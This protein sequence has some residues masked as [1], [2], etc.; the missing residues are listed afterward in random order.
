MFYYYP[1]KFNPWTKMDYAAL[2]HL[3][4]TLDNGNHDGHQIVIGVEPLENDNGIKGHNL[5]SN[6]E[7][8]IELIEEGLKPLFAHH[9]W[10]LNSKYEY[11]DDHT[12]N[13]V[14]SIVCQNT[15][16]I[17]DFIIDYCTK[18]EIAGTDVVLVLSED[19]YNMLP[20]LAAGDVEPGNPK[21]KHPKELLKYASVHFGFKNFVEENVR[22]VLYRNPYANYD[23]VKEYLQKSVFDLIKSWHHY[24]QYGYED[25]Y[26]CKEALYLR[27]LKSESPSISATAILIKPFYKTD[28][29]NKELIIRDREMDEVLLVRRTKM[30]YEGF[31]AL[32]GSFFSP[33]ED[34]NIEETAEV[35]ISDELDI[36]LNIKM[37][38][39]F[40]TYSNFVIDNKGIV[41]D[42]V[43]V[44][45][46]LSWYPGK[47]V[48]WGWFRMGE[49]PRMAFNHRQIIEDYLYE[50]N[51]S[52]QS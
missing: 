24:W 13:T 36:P 47:D 38:D 30:P 12:H 48:A 27:Q 29:F 23:E 44:K 8:R 43:Y 31:W 18:N 51:V 35:T 7:Q 25:E 16:S 4:T 14:V 41:V 2:E 37:E 50:N 45:E 49:L 39:Q 17:F 1:G 34:A 5:C 32:P 11:A 28:G 52:T 42:V 19:E 15:P 22:N 6:E 26:R 46:D 20:T 40:R 10:L 33:K 3:C 9:D 21:W